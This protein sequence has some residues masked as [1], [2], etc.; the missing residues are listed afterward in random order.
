MDWLKQNA[1]ATVGMLAGAWIAAYAGFHMGSTARV[2][3]MEG[4]PQAAAPAHAVAQ[5][6]PRP[7]TE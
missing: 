1:P 6:Y 2:A 7:H 4:G 5:S 3:E